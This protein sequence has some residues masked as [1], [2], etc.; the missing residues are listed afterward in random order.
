[1][2]LSNDRLRCPNVVFFNI[3]HQWEVIIAS[4]AK[5]KSL[6]EEKEYSQSQRLACVRAITERFPDLKLREGTTSG[7][8]LA[9]VSGGSLHSFASHLH[10]HRL[11][12][13]RRI[14][15]AHCRSSRWAH[16]R[17]RRRRCR[18]LAMR[19]LRSRSN[20]VDFGPPTSDQA[21]ELQIIL[22]A[23]MDQITDT[24]RV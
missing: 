8:E 12:C 18:P 6:M 3:E 16:G 13:R 15:V 11:L 9:N 22:R 24:S 19:W 2:T 23:S 1:M 17:G 14:D 10:S 4:R 7:E 20:E 5:L 21:L